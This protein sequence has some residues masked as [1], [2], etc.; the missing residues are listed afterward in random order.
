M[1]ANHFPDNLD[2][3]PLGLPAEEGPKEEC[4]VFGLFAPGEEVARITFFGLFALQHRGQESAG[5]A[6]SDGRR[7]RVHKDMGLV[8]QVFDEDVIQSLEGISAIGHT[9]YSTTGSSVLCNA[10]PIAGASRVGDIAVAHNGNL[11]NTHP[12]RC[13]LE[14]EGCTFETT[15]DSEVIAK[16]LTTTHT[17]CIEET[18]RQ[19][20][21]RLEGAYSLVILTPDKLIGVRD[22]Y[23]IRPLCLGRI[24]GSH[25]VLASESC[26]LVPVG[27]QYIREVEPGEVIV[28][29]RDGQHEFQAVPTRRHATCLFEFIYFARPDSMLYNRSLHQARR[30]MGHELAREHPVPNAHVVIPVPDTSIPAAIGYAEASRIPYGEGVIKNRYIQRTFIQPSQRM[31]DMGARMKYTPLKDTLAGK[32]VVMVDDSIVRGTTTGKLVRML[33][34]AGAEEVH[35]RITAPPVRHP[36]Y[37][38][39]DMANQEELVAARLSVE[40]IRQLIG[41]TSLGYLSLEGVVRAVGMHKDNF[42]RACFDGKYPITVPQDVRVSKLMLERFRNVAEPE[43]RE[44]GPD[45]GSPDAH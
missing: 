6:V 34:E 35:V 38:G 31:R 19:T 7:I 1:H 39:I 13:E 25:Y 45:D 40:E 4:G 10:Q 5:I 12:L 44:G 18:V 20:M 3:E 30:R 43:H 36:C 21:Q 15:N 14:A 9:R 23:G 17:G 2:T 41:A 22:P 29:D 16:L 42:C 32:K 37:Y 26:A 11:V 28:I 27:A 33:F 8:T 24:N